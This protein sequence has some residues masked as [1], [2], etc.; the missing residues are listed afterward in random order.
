MGMDMVTILI[1]AAKKAGIAP[2]LLVAVCHT[3][4]N[5]R[6]VHNMDDNGSP[7]YGVCQV[8]QETAQWMGKFYK[9]N[10]MS[11]LT[12]KELMTP[13]KNAEVA[14]KYLKYQ[15]DRYDN[16][17]CAAIAAY[18]AGSAVESKIVPGKPRNYKYVKKVKSKIEPSRGVAHLLTCEDAFK[19]RREYAQRNP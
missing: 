8:K 5:L 11:S 12:E 19:D 13:A 3:E 1:A 14:A 2:A 15:L 6:N 4:T 10:K 7:S 9:D 16:N 17:W 18:N